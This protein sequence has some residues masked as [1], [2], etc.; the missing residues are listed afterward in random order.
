MWG[1]APM[2]MPG[3]NCDIRPYGKSAH[4]YGR[5]TRQEGIFEHNPDRPLLHAFFM[6]YALIDNWLKSSIIFKGDVLLTSG[7]YQ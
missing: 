4:L 1:A 3:V 2:T 5:V 6:C 7:S